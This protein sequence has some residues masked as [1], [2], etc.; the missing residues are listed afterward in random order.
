MSQ[1]LLLVCLGITAFLYASVG[2]GGASGYLAFLALAGYAPAEMKSS[3]LCLNIIVSAI[4]FMQYC[5]QHH[6]RLRLLWPFAATSIPAA[7]IGSYVSVDDHVYKI[8]LALC[9]FVAVL[10]ILN[11][12]GKNNAEVQRRPVHIPVALIA[13]AGI[14]FLSG[15]L[16]IGG[17]ILLSPLL[18]VLNWANMKESAAASAC[19]ILLNSVAGLIGIA[20]SG[21]TLPASIVP[22]IIVAALGGITGS[23]LGSAKFNVAFMRYT[24]GIVLL[25]ACFKLVTG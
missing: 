23:Y 25:F 13:G 5:R 9:L 10:R 6:F 3:A 24:L 16:G 19:F 11:V 12:F 14:G 2:H 20:G 1:E 17:G 8:L 18:L 15:M 4:A 22:W 21:I 7:F